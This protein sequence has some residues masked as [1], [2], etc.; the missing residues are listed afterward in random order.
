MGNGLFAVD[1]VDVAALVAEHVGPRM[2]PAVLYKPAGTPVRD[3]D[4]PTA[5][6]PSSAP[7]PHKCRGF[8]NDF[9]PTQIDGTL[10]K[11][12]DR[13]VTLIA[14]TI[15][16]GAVPESGNTDT[17]F[18]EST[19]YLIHRVLSRDAAAAAYVLQVR[20]L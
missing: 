17:V 2:L 7:V 11:A 13:K 19:R 16:G 12:G 9:T 3:P 15:E 20:D 6:L 10:I 4:D 8:I 14:D 1:G 5:M 18:I